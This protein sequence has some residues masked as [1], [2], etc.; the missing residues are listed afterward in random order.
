MPSVTK[1]RSSKSPVKASLKSSKLK[2]V[3]KAAA[4]K[5]G[6]NGHGNGVRLGAK[7][8]V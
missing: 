7:S 1:S 5:N 4:G 3:G 6:H 8:V 2:K